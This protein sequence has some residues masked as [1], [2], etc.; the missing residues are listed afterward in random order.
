MLNHTL[1]RKSLLCISVATSLVLAGCASPNGSQS[2][3]P[4]NGN[5][6]KMKSSGIGAGV[7]CAIGAFGTHMMGG[8]ALAGCAVGAAGGAAVGYAKARQDEIDE[9]RLAQQQMPGSIVQTREVQVIDRSTGQSSQAQVLN[10][11]AVPL[12]PRALNNPEGRKVFNNLGALAKKQDAFIVVTGAGTP[13]QQEQAAAL[14]RRGGANNVS[15]EPDAIMPA[16]IGLPS[17][18]VII[19]TPI[20]KSSVISV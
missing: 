5:F 2:F 1:L 6:A 19:V 4:G 15:I 20:D 9:V 7:G 12:S 17:D 3:Q 11:M 13:R 14:L 16:Q 18:M 10:V 8:N